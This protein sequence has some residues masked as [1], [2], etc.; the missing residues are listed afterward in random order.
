M[1][2]HKAEPKSTPVKAPRKNES[3]DLC[4]DLC[5]GLFLRNVLLIRILSPFMSY[6][7]FALK[8]A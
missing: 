3:L 4:G 7:A 5:G 2:P 1:T 6:P 8:G